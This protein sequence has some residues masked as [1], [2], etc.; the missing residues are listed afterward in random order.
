MNLVA[1]NDQSFWSQV[2]MLLVVEKSVWARAWLA[3]SAA[4]AVE[5]NRIVTVRS[6]EE[7]Q[8]K[9]M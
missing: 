8:F 2:E 1:V 3:S 7:Y 4:T 9:N 6:V 5:E